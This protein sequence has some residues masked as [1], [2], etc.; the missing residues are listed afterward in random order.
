MAVAFK[1]M[2][3]DVDSFGGLPYVDGGDGRITK[4]GGPQG[5]LPERALGCSLGCVSAPWTG[6]LVLKQS[7]LQAALDGGHGVGLD[8][9][10][11]CLS[12]TARPP[13]PPIHG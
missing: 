11:C 5:L 4:R 10:P 6:A 7:G 12:F 8:P 3:E 13:G 1:A 2:H 9:R